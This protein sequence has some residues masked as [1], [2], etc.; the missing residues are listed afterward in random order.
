[1]Q[2]SYW[3]YKTWFANVDFTIV[4]SGIVGLTCALQLK[5][6]HPESKVLVL[7]RGSLPQGASTKNA[8]FACFGS[9]SELLSDLKTH[10][11]DEVVDLVRRRWEGILALRKLLG[12]KEIGFEQLGGHELFLEGHSELY[13]SCLYGMEGMNRM[14]GPIFG[15]GPFI[16]NNNRFQFGK[17]QGK[18]ITHQLEGQLDTGKMMQAL[19]QTCLLN[20]IPVLN[21][22]EVESVRDF[23]KGAVIITKDFEFDTGNVFVATNGF[24]SKLLKTETVR[25]ARAQVLITKPIKDLSIKGTF[26]FDEGYYYFRNIDNRI[27]FGGGRNLDLKGEETSDFGQTPLIQQRLEELLKDVI[28]PN[29]KVEIDQRWSGIMGI[30]KQKVP[31]VKQVSERVFCGVRLG[32]MGVALG[33]LV[34]K[35]LADLA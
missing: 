13:Q 4:G 18:Y 3:E 26:H 24:A 15:K 10:T 16:L 28:L 25:P 35:E 17:I 29:Q 2:L 34:G 9:I 22:I 20:G 8:G 23:G 32:G 1:M 33:S 11:E 19:L 21:G 12:D 30:G 7:E 5:K 31:I 14:L 27:L 6:K